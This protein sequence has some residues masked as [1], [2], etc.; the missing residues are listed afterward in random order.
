MTT[1][2]FI[3]VYAIIATAV[4]MAYFTYHRWEHVLDARGIRGETREVMLLHL[5]L[6]AAAIGAAWPV[7][8]VL[9]L[10]AVAAGR[11]GFAVLR[12]SRTADSAIQLAPARSADR[13]GAVPN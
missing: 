4:G 3:A 7:G 5:M 13:A 12:L 9:A 2:A 10:Y 11:P 1:I 8:I 6:G